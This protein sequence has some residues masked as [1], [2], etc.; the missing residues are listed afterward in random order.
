MQSETSLEVDGADT[1]SSAIEKLKKEHEDYKGHKEHYDIL[2]VDLKLPGL[3]GAEMGGL[4]IIT[5]SLK[6]DPLRPI[7]VISGHWT[8]EL[9]KKTVS[10]GV[11]D[12]IEKNDDSIDELVKSI[13]RAISSFNEKIMRSGN[14]FSHSSK[15]PTVFGGRT[16]ELE[17]FEQRLYRAFTNIYEHFLVLGS[18]GIGKT[19][20]LIEYRKLCQSRGYLASIVPLIPLN[21]NTSSLEAARAV[22]N[23]IIN[24]L[25]YKINQSGQ[26][27]K[28]IEFFDSIGITILGT[29]IQFSRDTT[30]KDLSILTFLH[31]TLLRLWQDLKEKTEVLV[32]LFDDIDN[33]CKMP[34]IIITL[35][36]V[37]LMDSMKDAKILIGIASSPSNW[38]NLTT[39]ESY[40]SL[41]RYF[42]SR[43]ELVPLNKIELR[44]TILK[45]LYR[46]GV[47]FSDE[48][49][50]RIYE[51]TKGHPFKMQLLCYHLF[52]NQLSRRVE[53]DVWDRAWQSTL[54]DLKR[55]DIK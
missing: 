44:D 42:I 35:K 39:C 15:E 31:D 21:E 26:Y 14:P 48:V 23:G 37:L 18:P 9:V 41:N 12:F 20:L 38:V 6:L 1:V 28:V 33:F 11:S 46:T 22:V 2:V 4:E 49:I 16:K 29:G 13:K 17:F 25:P 40:H 8:I 32:V 7:I 51:V 43:V 3:S 34:E 54:E 36:Q 27:R 10:Q 45:S 53:I 55:S 24:G 30:V 50:E 19:T 52:N 47:S 5:E